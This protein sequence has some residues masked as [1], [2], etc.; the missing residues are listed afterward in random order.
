M[1]VTYETLKAHAETDFPEQ[2]A[3]LPPYDKYKP[4]KLG[5]HLKLRVGQVRAIGKFVKPYLRRPQFV[6]AV[7]VGCGFELW[8][9][10]TAR[11]AISPHNVRFDAPFC[12]LYPHGVPYHSTRDLDII[13]RFYFESLGESVPFDPKR[14]YFLQ[15]AQQFRSAC[16]KI[17]RGLANSTEEIGN[18][19]QGKSS[20]I[21]HALILTR[22]RNIRHHHGM[23][24]F[25]A[26]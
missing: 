9:G 2:F 22:K 20:V 17:A 8:T 18:T 13:L 21:H 4:E 19:T 12:Y 3:K 16:T 15:Y 11:T 23:H 5:D 10:N 6:Y 14:P 25:L 7:V 26:L 1:Y 24:A